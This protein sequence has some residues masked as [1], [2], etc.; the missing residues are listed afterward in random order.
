[1]STV[2]LKLVVPTTD[3][4]TVA[5]KPR[6]PRRRPNAESRSREYLHDH[7]V[8]RLIKTAKRSRNGHRD[9]TMILIAYRHGLRVAELVALQWSQIDLRSGR[10]HVNR[11]KGS[12][13]SVHPLTGTELRALRQLQREQGNGVSH[14]FTSERGAP[15]S[16]AGFRKLIARL[17][18]EAAFTFPLHPHMLRHSCGYK[19]A[20]QGVDTRSLAAYLGHASL[21]NTSRYT[22]IAANRFKDFWQD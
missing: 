11:V 4:G 13:P 3:N 7:E 8:A 16:A 18:I 21:N 10:I 22:Q 14:L 20:N 15:L 6:P 9:A 1:M 12:I 2:A 19:L 17:G 5:Q